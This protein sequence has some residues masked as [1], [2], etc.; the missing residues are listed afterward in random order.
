MCLAQAQAE[1]HGLYYRLFK[2]TSLTISFSDNEQA[3]KFSMLCVHEAPAQSNS[4]NVKYS[5]LL[6]DL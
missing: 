2:L 1:Q 6:N 5:A 3:A 4:G